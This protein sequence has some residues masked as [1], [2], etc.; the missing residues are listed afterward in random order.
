MEDAALFELKPPV[1]IAFLRDALYRVAE[2]LVGLGDSVYTKTS[3]RLAIKKD[4]QTFLKNVIKCSKHFV[5]GEN[6]PGTIDL[7]VRV[8]QKQEEGG[9]VRCQSKPR[10][11]NWVWL[12]FPST[13][14][15]PLKIKG[16]NKEVPGQESCWLASEPL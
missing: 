13:H 4:A 1:E 10:N 6:F 15:H 3:A 7:K 8:A 2:K 9:G 14:T 11:N 5:T 16:P 12:P